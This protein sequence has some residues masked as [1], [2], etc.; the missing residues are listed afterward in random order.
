MGKECFSCQQNAPL[1]LKQ[2][3]ELHL[4]IYNQTGEVFW[5]FKESTNDNV[6]I[7]DAKSFSKIL[8]Q[9]KDNEGAQW[10]HIAEFGQSNNDNVFRDTKDEKPKT[11]KPRRNRGATK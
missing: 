7:A 11:T 10:C 5:F 9:I 4:K 2:R 6:K 8:E 3:L 1:S